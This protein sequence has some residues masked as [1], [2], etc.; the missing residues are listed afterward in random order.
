MNLAE[1]LCELG[2]PVAYYPSLARLLGG[3]PEALFLCQLIYWTGKGADKESWIFKTAAELTDETGLSYRE[4]RRA[5]RVLKTFG[6]LQE[7]FN[8]LLHR[9]YFWIDSGRLE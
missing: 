8:R 6:I 1:T 4:Q 2:H 5:R 3:V 9:T 7:K